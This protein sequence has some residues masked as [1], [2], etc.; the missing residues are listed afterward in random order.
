MQLY[1]VQIYQLFGN[2]STHEWILIIE[3][4]IYGIYLFFKTKSKKTQNNFFLINKPLSLLTITKLEP[5]I[6]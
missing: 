4:F 3:I 5:P 1:T 6:C 2:Y